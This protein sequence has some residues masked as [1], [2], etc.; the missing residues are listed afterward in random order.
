MRRTEFEI[1]SDGLIGNDIHA[2][3]R[4][5][6]TRGPQRLVSYQ[7]V[8]WDDR[9]LKSEWVYSDEIMPAPIRETRTGFAKN[10]ND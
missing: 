9:D 5:I 4:A 10:L 7:C 6:E 8:W 1:G 2:R 3:I